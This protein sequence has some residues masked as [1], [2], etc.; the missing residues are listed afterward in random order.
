MCCSDV[1]RL[2]RHGVRLT[3]VPTSSS[4]LMIVIGLKYAS[5]PDDSAGLSQ[6]IGGARSKHVI[7]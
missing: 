5:W 2:V 6:Q 7:L 3:G 4:E 1:V